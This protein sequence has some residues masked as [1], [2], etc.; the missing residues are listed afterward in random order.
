[1][2]KHSNLP[3]FKLPHEGH[4]I[5][6]QLR[7]ATGWSGNESLL[8]IARAGWNALNGGGDKIGAMREVMTAAVAH[9]ETQRAMQKRVSMTAAKLREARKRL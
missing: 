4:H 1:M 5:V 6:S 3:P 9:F 7:N 8:F 2:S